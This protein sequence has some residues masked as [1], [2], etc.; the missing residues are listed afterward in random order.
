MNLAASQAGHSNCVTASGLA[1]RRVRIVG[2]ACRRLKLH[3]IIGDIVN[4]TYS[5]PIRLQ[6]NTPDRCSAHAKWH[7]K[8]ARS[9]NV[10]VLQ[11][12]CGVLVRPIHG[13]LPK[14]PNQWPSTAPSQKKTVPKATA[15]RLFRKRSRWGSQRSPAPSTKSTA[16]RKQ[17]AHKCIVF[18]NCA[19]AISPAMSV[20]RSSCGLTTTHQGA[21]SSRYVHSCESAAYSG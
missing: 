7:F 18:A 2:D 13:S 17:C 21:H 6:A 11:H 15:T 20:Q 5:A 1:W 9:L 14:T 3:C 4:R 10:H 19:T 8:I 12:I 16:A